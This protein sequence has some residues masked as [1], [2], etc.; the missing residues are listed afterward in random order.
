MTSWAKF[1]KRVCGDKKE[2]EGNIFEHA[3]LIATIARHIAV[4]DPILEVGAGTGVM[5]APLAS[6]GA[7]VISIDNDAEVLRMAK[8]N[9]K[10]L[11]VDIKY[12]KADAFHLPF[13][14]GQFKCAFSEGLLEHYDDA[15]IGRLVFEHQRVAH[16]VVVSVPLKGSQN[17]ALGNER[18]LTMEEWEEKFIPMGANR[19]TLYGSEPN[20]CFTFLRIK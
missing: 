11:G 9:A 4:G 8:V 16:V 6:N 5:A 20:A 12:R 10:L 13:N 1:Y 3:T 15:D 14:D 18:W 17:I 7:K 2:L 19:G